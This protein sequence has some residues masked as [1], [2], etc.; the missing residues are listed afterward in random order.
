VDVKSP[1]KREDPYVRAVMEW[2]RRTVGLRGWGFEDWYGA[3]PRLL[4]NV[5]FLAG[6]R[7]RTVIDESLIPAVLRA[8]VGGTAITDL[9]RAVPEADPVLVRPVVCCTC[10]GP[11]SA[12]GR[13]LRRV[14]LREG[15]AG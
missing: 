6:Y 5:R 7:R 4:G 14:A 15:R 8:A 11:G 9:E 10:C 13:T 3:P 2:T 1:A 12:A